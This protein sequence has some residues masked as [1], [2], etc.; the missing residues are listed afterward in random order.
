MFKTFLF[1]F[2]TTFLLTAQD[3]PEA[4]SLLGAPLRSEKD[5]D[6]RIAAADA[7]LAKAP[8][9]LEAMLKAGQ[10]RDALMRYNASIGVYNKAI[11]AFPNDP[12]PYRW[13]GHRQI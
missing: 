1:L 3:K 8:G 2:V 11:Q 9:K 6:G 12:R 13:R 4:T 5:T 7:E 10:A